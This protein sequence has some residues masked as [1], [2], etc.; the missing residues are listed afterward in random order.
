LAFLAAFGK[1]LVLA[2]GHGCVK[3]YG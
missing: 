1:A 3:H 2:D